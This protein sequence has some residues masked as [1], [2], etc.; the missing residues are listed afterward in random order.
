MAVCLRSALGFIFIFP[1]LEVGVFFTAIGGDPQ[2][3]QLSVVN[4]ELYAMNL[5]SCDEYRSAFGMP[6]SSYSGGTED[7]YGQPLGNCSVRMLS[8]AF[9]DYLDHRM[10]HQVGT[11]LGDGPGL[12]GADLSAGE[13]ATTSNYPPPP[14]PKSIRA[15]PGR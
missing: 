12:S 5:S 3:L 10:A 15:P 7:D 11:V 13:G 9:L 6:G 2:G 8:C 14:A 1:V 4:E